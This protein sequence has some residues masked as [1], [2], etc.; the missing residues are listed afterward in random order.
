MNLIACNKDCSYQK[1]GYCFLT[2]T[3]YISDNKVDGC[4][5]YRQVGVLPPETTM[6]KPTERI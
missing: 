6:K 4:C 2:D 5:Y 3:T 1:D